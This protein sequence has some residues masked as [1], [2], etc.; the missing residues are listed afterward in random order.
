MSSEIIHERHQRYRAFTLDIITVYTAGLLA[1]LAG[2]SWG[3]VN[4]DELINK[5]VRI[6]SGD[7]SP[8]DHFYPQLTSLISA[9]ACGVLF[10][11]GRFLGLF[12]SIEEFRSIYFENDEMF[13]VAARVAHSG[14]A[15]SMGP[16]AYL[17]TRHCG[18][19]R[20]LA[21]LIGLTVS[22]S[23]ASIW[24]SH[25]AKPQN[26]MTA[27][28]LAAVAL[29]IAYMN[30]G[31]QRG[32]AIGIGTASGIAGAFLHSAALIILPLAITT[33][34]LT[35]RDPRTRSSI[36]WLEASLAMLTALIIWGLLSILDLL[37]FSGFLDYQIIQSQMSIR[38]P[39]SLSTLWNDALPVAYSPTQGM[40]PAGFFLAPIAAVISRMRSVRWLSVTFMIIP[41]ILAIIIGDRVIPRLF[42]PFTIVLTLLTCLSFATLT[43]S[44]NRLYRWG[45][46]A[47]L[48]CILAGHIWGGQL[49]ASEALATPASTF[50]GR[51]LKALITPQGPT[52]MSASIH[53][54][55]LQPSNA[56]RDLMYSRHARLAQKYQIELPPRSKMREALSEVPG[57][58]PIIEIPWVIGGLDRTKPENVKII[59]PYAWPI[60]Y[61]E[62]RLDFWLNQGVMIYVLQDLQFFISEEAPKFYAQFHREIKNR[63]RQV[64]YIDVNRPLFF[65]KDYYIFDCRI[66]P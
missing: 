49:V 17:I 6:L 63:C 11:G 51:E 40:G 58:Y 52:V 53:Q 65:E 62:W 61:D 10:I 56:A 37:H 7:F 27:L 3:G 38:G 19:S 54:S 1:R 13:R 44:Q 45:G 42:L 31:G 9:F 26:G 21:I 32:L 16:T 30:D 24:F 23:P 36:V 29:A 64:A 4:M 12:D 48:F 57:G 18:F 55:G 25:F 60:Q 43:E 20:K 28:V 35:L 50:V 15:A 5:A 22:F 41:I 59:R 33:L 46:F 66:A 14:I 39:A 34:I 8:V 47:G 2:I